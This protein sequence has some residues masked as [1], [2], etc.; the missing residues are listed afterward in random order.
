MAF[1]ALTKNVSDCVHQVP[2]APRL[3]LDHRSFCQ[4]KA[5]HHRVLLAQEGVHHLQAGSDALRQSAP[6]HRVVAS[7]GFQDHPHVADSAPLDGERRQA[8]VVPLL[9]HAFHRGVGV[10]VVA[11]AGVAAATAD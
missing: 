2:L 9:A 10:A 1:L 11:L 7:R 4:D 5:G 6:D 8:V 3:A